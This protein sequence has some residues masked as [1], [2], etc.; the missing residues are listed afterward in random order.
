MR[1]VRTSAYALPVVFAIGALTLAGCSASQ[2]ALPGKGAADSA[3]I[4]PAT[5]QPA[6]GQPASG[7]KTGP[8]TTLS[9]QRQVVTTGKVTMTVDNPLTV[10]D[11]VAGIVEQAGGHID[12]RSQQAPTGGDHGSAWLTVRI[13]SASLTAT[14]SSIKKLGKVGS[15][16]ITST[17]VTAA[18]QDL[19]ARITALQTSVDRLLTLMTKAASVQDLMAVET[20]LSERQA[21]LESLQAQKRVLSDQIDYATITV[22]LTSSAATVTV[23]E[24]F[25]SGFILGWQALVGFFAGTLVVIGVV[26]P[27]LLLFAV[28][29]GGI[30]LLVRFLIR[31]GKRPGQTA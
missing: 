7:T 14:L 28:I 31:R 1:R 25:W 8:V 27:W 13:P 2:S 18:S 20:T 9:T 3:A 22:S 19:T 10:A 29:S 23:P 17:D 12:N 26:L 4:A 11:T 21:N 5:I 30:L 16:S 15:A 24:N 6:P